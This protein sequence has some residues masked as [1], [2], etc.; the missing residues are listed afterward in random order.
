MDSNQF[1][2]LNQMPQFKRVFPVKPMATI[3]KLRILIVK[4]LIRLILFLEFNI[5]S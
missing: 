1:N 4:N 2:H 3:K 5:H